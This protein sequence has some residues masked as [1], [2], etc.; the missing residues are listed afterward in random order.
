EPYEANDQMA[1]FSLAAYNPKAPKSDLCNGVIVV[2][3]TDPCGAANKK[4]G[5]SFSPGTAGPDRA[6]VNNNNHNIAPR[7]GV[8]WDLRG[9]GK[10]AIRAG[11]G[12]FYQRERVSPQVGLTN[13]AP[14]ALTATLNRPLDSAPALTPSILGGSG[15][16]GKDP[17][18]VTPNSWQWNFSV[19]QQLAKDTSLELAYVGNRGIHLTSY[20][21]LNQVPT[22]NRVQAAFQTDA[23]K[24]N[25]LR[26]AANYG[27]ISFF[28]R[29]GDSYYDALQVLFRSRMGNHSN[30][31]LSYT[32]SHSIA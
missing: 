17:R 24:V 1:S 10:T 23:G 9:D 7:L 25:A 19:E 21:D 8:A 16:H 20:Y 18:G 4:Y 5:L 11:V 28:S 30:L 13:T 3:G 15:A 29:D 32:W 31:Q 14:F 12:Q 2:P 26:P 6:L 22:A 27:T